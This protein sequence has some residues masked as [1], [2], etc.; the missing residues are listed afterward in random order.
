MSPAAAPEGTTIRIY[1][2]SNDNARRFVDR[3]LLDH[4]GRRSYNNRSAYDDS[5]FDYRRRLDDRR[6]G[7]LIFVRVNF[8]LGFPIAVRERRR[9]KSYGTRHA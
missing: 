4:H 5:S 9:G 7:R 1:G 8:P 3:I 6:R 2:R